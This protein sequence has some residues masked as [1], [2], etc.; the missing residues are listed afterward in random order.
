M[1]LPR[2]RTPVGP[3]AL[4]LAN[5]TGAALTFATVKAPANTKFRGS[6]T[7]LQHSLPTLHEARYRAPCK[8]RFRLVVSLYREGVESS[9]L[10]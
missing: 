7:R 1:P 2:S 6:I 10:R 4:T 5:S 9:G 8:A 3:A